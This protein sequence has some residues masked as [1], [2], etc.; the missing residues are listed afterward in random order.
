MCSGPTT[1][2][3]NAGDDSYY[4]PANSNENG[5]DE[6]FKFDNGKPFVNIYGNIADAMFPEHIDMDA[7]TSTRFEQLEIAR[8][9]YVEVPKERTR[10][11]LYLY[12]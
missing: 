5:P 12:S 8:M 2:S 3:F 9:A 7:D 1:P 6:G 4:E 10:C 11:V